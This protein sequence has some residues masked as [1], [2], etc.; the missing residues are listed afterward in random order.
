MVEEVKQAKEAKLQWLS[1]DDIFLEVFHISH[2]EYQATWN[3]VYDE[4][5]TITWNKDSEL[6]IN[7]QQ[8]LSNAPFDIAHLEDKEWKNKGLGIIEVQKTSS[9]MS[10]L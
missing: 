2:E 3:E 5:Y 4:D 10:T 8:A 6:Y 1:S 9:R 7:I